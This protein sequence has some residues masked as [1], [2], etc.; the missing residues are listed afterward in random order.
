MWT[1]CLLSPWCTI[2]KPL[3]DVVIE[4]STSVVGPLS[5]REDEETSGLCSGAVGC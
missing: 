5:S 3:D 4:V 2:S 1:S